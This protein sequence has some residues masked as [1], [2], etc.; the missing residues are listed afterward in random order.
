MRPVASSVLL[1]LL[2]GCATS[3]EVEIW[4]SMR[5]VLR[6]GRTEG[7]VTLE[8][9][10]RPGAVGVGLLEGLEAEV[11]VD[12]GVVHLASVCEGQL[13]QRELRSDDRAALLALAHVPEWSTVELPHVRGM[14]QLEEEVFRAARAAGLDPH[15][16][17]PIRIVGRFHGLDVHVLDRSCP[18]ANPD[19]PPPWRLRGAQ[20]EGVL[21]GVYADAHAGRITH[22]GERLHLHAVVLTAEE[23]R[24][25]GHVDGVE[26]TAGAKLFLPRSIQQ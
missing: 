4:G 9:V 25:S 12:D 16:I 21:V 10:V 7:R 1:F 11:T 26:V 19:G 8:D 5:E 18:L 2:A 20:A 24:I 17:L 13:V 23:R 14:E 6:Q 3:S 15:R 22:H